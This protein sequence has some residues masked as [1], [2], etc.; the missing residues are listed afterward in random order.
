MLPDVSSH[1]STA[2]LLIAALLL[3]TLSARGAGG[4]LADRVAAEIEGLQAFLKTN[5]ATDE[6]MADVTRSSGPLLEQAEAARHDGYSLLALLR[7]A[8]AR[9]DIKAVMYL[10]SRSPEQLKDNAAFEAEWT[11]IGRSLSA[12][13]AAPASGTLAGVTPAAVR[14]I[15]EAA[16]PQV[17]VYHQASLEYGRNTMPAEGLFYLGAAQAQR[18]LAELCRELSRP[19]GLA[20]PPLRSLEGEL[21]ELEAELLGAYRPPA[22]IDRHRDFIAASATLKEARELDSAGLRYGAM[23]KYLQAAQRVAPLHGVPAQLDAVALGDGLQAL[24]ARLDDGETDHSLGQLFLETARADVARA[25]DEAPP[26]LASEIVSD[27]APRY[28]AALE[29]ARPPLPR[30]EARATVTL[31]RWPYT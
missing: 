9:E 16:L 13:L 26:R 10:A 8:R 24:A 21:D 30:P 2:L 12:D 11:R 1:R 23:L 29:V 18:S 20:A 5:A 4:V 28:F 25:N 31:V 22:S 3:P 27:L 14:A 7:L 19:S 6:I 15:G 17:R